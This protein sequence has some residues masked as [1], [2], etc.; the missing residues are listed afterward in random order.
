MALSSNGVKPDLQSS[1]R[2]VNRL[3]VAVK[4]LFDTFARCSLWTIV[5]FLW[6]TEGISHFLKRV[7]QFRFTQALSK[8]F[9]MAEQKTFELIHLYVGYESSESLFAQFFLKFFN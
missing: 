5:D 9:R 1:K 6:T 3:I 2:T 8:L 7:A 4:M